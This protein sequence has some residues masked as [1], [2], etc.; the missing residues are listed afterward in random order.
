MPNGSGCL[1]AES[2]GDFDV[3]VGIWRRS[4]Y[5][6]LDVFQCIQRARDQFGDA[7][8]VQTAQQLANR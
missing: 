4:A 1:R 8:A 5:E 2:C 3:T 7:P 6:C